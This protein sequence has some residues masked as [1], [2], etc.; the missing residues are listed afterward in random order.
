[1]LAIAAGSFVYFR[2]VYTRAKRLR[3]VE[4]G[5]L[6]R[7]G[8]M[9][10]DGFVE[11]VERHGIR[12]VIN[13]QDD[14]PDPDLAT[15]F[16]GGETVKESALCRRLGVRYVW[17]APDLVPRNHARGVR[18]RVVDEFLALMD[19]ESTYPALIHCKAG[20]HRTGLLCAIWRMEYQGWSRPEAL[21]ELKAHGFGDWACTS[22]NDYVAQYVLEYRRRPNAECGMRSAEFRSV[23]RSALRIP[24]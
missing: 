11:A 21:A 10:V 14:C 22:A 1:M 7:G 9:R 2:A 17:L 15:A 13:V 24:N 16:L 23:P 3:V 20:L 12:T 4:P 8:L 6:Y 18:P 19:R 5:R